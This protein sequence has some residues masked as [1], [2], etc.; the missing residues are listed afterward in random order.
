MTDP[1]GALALIEQRVADAEHDVRQAQA[2][3]ERYQAIVDTLKQLHADVRQQQEEQVYA[4]KPPRA[5]R[6]EVQARVLE[7]VR[8]GQAPVDNKR[9]RAAAR[10]LQR[11]GKIE[12]VD[13]M[14][15]LPLKDA[16][17]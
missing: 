10:A 16:A 15:R 2:C 3:V 12:L 13:G 8:N 11:A 9:I 5:A 14:Y 7:M 6:G 1:T 4:A 17:Q